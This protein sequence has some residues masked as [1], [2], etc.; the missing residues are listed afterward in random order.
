MQ[1]SRPNSR[2]L[3]LV[4]GLVVAALVA[5]AAALGHQSG[6]AVSAFVLIGGL[7]LYEV[8]G[9]TEWAKLS[10]PDADERQRA[11]GREAALVSYAAMMLVAVGGFL[12]EVVRGTA[13]G[14]FT[15]VCAV[16]GFT[17]MLAQFVLTRRR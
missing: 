8:Y 1:V 14:P 17:L 4:P 12:V 2:V 5:F 16:G 15:L 7:Q 6:V 11:I 10:G 9:K 13:P 3:R